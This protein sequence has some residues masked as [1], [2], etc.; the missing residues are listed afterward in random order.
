MRIRRRI[1]NITV[2]VTDHADTE[3]RFL[4]AD[5][6]GSYSTAAGAGG[7]DHNDWTGYCR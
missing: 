7:H 4:F 1:R 6:F 2:R 3:V 5:P